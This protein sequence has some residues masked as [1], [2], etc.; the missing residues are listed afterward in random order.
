MV[1]DPLY[2]HQ[3]AFNRFALAIWRCM[4]CYDPPSINE[5]LCGWFTPP[6]ELYAGTGGHL[7]YVMTHERMHARLVFS[8]LAFCCDQDVT[9]SFQTPACLASRAV[10]TAKKMGQPPF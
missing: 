9:S 5:V 6:S 2:Q 10:R 3:R 7:A 8:L 1:G 4:P